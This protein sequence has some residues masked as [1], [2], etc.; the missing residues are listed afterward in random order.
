MKVDESSRE[1]TIVH[2]H[3]TAAQV[4]LKTDTRP[5]LTKSQSLLAN[6][7]GSITLDHDGNRMLNVTFFVS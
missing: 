4:S 7:T 6:F 3:G 2:E 1:I 5:N